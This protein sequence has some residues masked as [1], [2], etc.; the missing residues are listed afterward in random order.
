VT[1]GEH[2]KFASSSIGWIIGP[3]LALFGLLNPNLHYSGLVILMGVIIWGLGGG[4]SYTLNK[5][6]AT[7]KKKKNSDP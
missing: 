5:E 6:I 3:A 1:F 2:F 4:I 7:R